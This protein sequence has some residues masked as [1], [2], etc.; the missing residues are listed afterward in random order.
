MIRAVDLLKQY[1]TVLRL[2]GKFLFL[3]A[4]RSAEGAR[5][6]IQLPDKGTS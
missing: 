5:H 6:Q 4:G 1:Y 3:S 2:G